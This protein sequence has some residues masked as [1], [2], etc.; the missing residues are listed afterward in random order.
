MQLHLVCRSCSISVPIYIYTTSTS[1]LGAA[2]AKDN[3][4]IGLCGLDVVKPFRS[5][6]YEMFIY[7]ESHRLGP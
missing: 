7:L 1:Y 2:R 5:R 3:V 6:A 4:S